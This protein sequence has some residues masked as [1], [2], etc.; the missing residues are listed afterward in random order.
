VHRYTC[1][2]KYSRKPLS[3]DLPRERGDGRTQIKTSKTSQQH[4]SKAYHSPTTFGK[5]TLPEQAGPYGRACV[6]RGRS[7]ASSPTA[8]TSGTR[9]I[10]ELEPLRHHS[11]NDDI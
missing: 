10:C 8:S 4:P 11:G 3:W 5:H 7:H 6:D 9:G 2:V 1:A